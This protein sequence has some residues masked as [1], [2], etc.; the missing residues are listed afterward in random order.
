MYDM[1]SSSTVEVQD[2][3]RFFAPSYIKSHR[4]TLQH[5]KVASAISFCRSE[6][7]GTHTDCCDECGHAHISYNSCRNRHCPKCQGLAREQWLSDR[8]QDL[9]PV[10]YFHAVFTIPDLL[11]PL[12]LRNQKILYDL[13][14]KCVS[15]TLSELAADK[16]YLGAQIGF[17]TIL[18]TWGQNLMDHPHIHCIVPGG[19]L[20]FD[21]LHWVNSRK[22]FFIPVKVLSKKFRGKFIYYLKQLY[23]DHLLKFP[24]KISELATEDA[25]KLMI[26]QLFDKDWVVYCKKPF[27]TSYHVLE[28]LGRYTHR[29]AISNNRL[30]NVNEQ[31][32]TFRWRDY[33]DKSKEKLMTIEGHEFVRRF[34]MHVL[35]YRFVK[36][37]HFGILSNRNRQ[38]K[39]I[40]CKKLTGVKLYLTPK[41]LSKVE[42]L[43]KLTGRDVTLCPCCQK[44]HMKRQSPLPIMTVP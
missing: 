34:L 25:F 31:S 43:F 24:G 30:V 29:V 10:P 36:I 32:V 17:T 41:K 26:N 3:F 16:K 21:G 13:L 42:L 40:K 4:L 9:L 27:K 33:R 20:S 14:F 19:G 7:L 11:N 35:P 38:S 15:E 1:A 2:I 22:K 39:L 18:H 12:I 37:R 8:Q 28:Y 6:R 23:A 44:G 5:L